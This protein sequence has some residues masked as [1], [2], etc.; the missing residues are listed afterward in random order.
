MKIFGG[1]KNSLE[2]KSVQATMTTPVF[3]LLGKTQAGKTSIAACLTGTGEEG[4]GLGFHRTTREPRLHAWP[5]P[6]SPPLLHF[7][8][9]PG[10]GADAG[11]AEE[12]ARKAMVQAEDHAH[13]I[14]VAVRAEDMALGALV[15]A[16]VEIRRRHRDWPVI[17]AQ[18]RLHDLYPPGAGHLLPY[19]FMGTE[20]DFQRAGVPQELARALIAQ[21]QCFASIPGEPPSFVPIDFTREEHGHEPRLYGAEALLDA[22]GQTQPA[23][24]IAL[25]EMQDRLEGARLRVILPWALVAAAAEAPPLPLIGLVG[26]TT[27]QGLMLKA[28]ADRCGVPWTWGLAWRFLAVLGPTALAS[29]GASAL[30]RQLLKLGVGPGTA[31]AAATAF[32][33]TWAAGEAAMAW[34]GALGRGEEPDEESVRSA[35]K[36]GFEEAVAWWKKNRDP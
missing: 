20:A 14:I 6:P 18:T 4:I 25:R 36:S 32:A 16:L 21:R 7:L 10:I 22:I 1:S 35:W 34:F 30:V 12:E 23:T 5:P 3:W 8:D 11:T 17:V 2:R 13:V 31:V 15:N 27:G 28:I 33:V 24:V 19:P 26:A 9:T 29:A